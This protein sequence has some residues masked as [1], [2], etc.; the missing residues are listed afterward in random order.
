MKEYWMNCLYLY[1]IEWVFDVGMIF[2]MLLSC[3]LCS[4][5]KA[6]Y[7]FIFCAL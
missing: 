2:S 6:V 3:L 5:I 7:I 1:W 4:L